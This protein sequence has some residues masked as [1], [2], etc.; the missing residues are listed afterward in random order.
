[1][2]V[3]I[4]A[5]LANTLPCQEPYIATWAVLARLP[6]SELAR[7]VWWLQTATR[8]PAEKEDF[9]E[10]GSVANRAP[11]DENR[12]GE[13]SDRLVAPVA[14]D[15]RSTEQEHTDPRQRL[16]ASVDARTPPPPPVAHRAVIR[17]R[18][19]IPHEGGSDEGDQDA[20][21][22][23]YVLDAQGPLG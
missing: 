9:A 23:W 21:K 10:I 5:R 18:A 2:Y 7:S 19:G 8:R 6:D 14:P 3:S 11:K 1:M 17:G 20:E 15:E 12:P 22:N 4:F 16:S 13:N